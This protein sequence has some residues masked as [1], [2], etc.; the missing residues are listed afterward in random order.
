MK[1]KQQKKLK[2]PDSETIDTL[3]LAKDND[4]SCLYV[5]CYRQQQFIESLKRMKIIQILERVPCGH[6]LTNNIEA[7]IY[8][9]I[10]PGLLKNIIT[11]INDKLI[12]DDGEARRQRLYDCGILQTKEYIF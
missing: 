10:I 1:A 11:N 9:C 12:T 7:S 6:P 8:F 4:C 2:I 3:K 5:F